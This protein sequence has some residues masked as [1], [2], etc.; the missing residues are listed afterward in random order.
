MGPAAAIA[1]FAAIGVGFAFFFE[2]GVYALF[3]APLIAIPAIR[4]GQSLYQRL[5]WVALGLGLTGGLSYLTFLSAANVKSHGIK[6]SERYAVGN[7][8]A[9]V[10]AQD[11][12]LRLYDTPGSLAQLLAQT[13]LED[14]RTVSNIML[15]MKFV[16]KHFDQGPRKIA[17]APVDGYMIAIYKSGHDGVPAGAGKRWM[18][19]AWPMRINATGLKAYCITPEEDI[20]ETAN[21]EQ[22]YEGLERVPDWTACLQGG[23]FDRP[24]DG[25]AGDGAEWHRWRGKG[26]RRSKAADQKG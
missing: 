7:L 9:L 24:K 16:P 1:A 5:G 18:A 2:W 3:A 19:Y 23:F 11:H 14:G 26:T 8:R 4:S 22:R 20:F 25:I 17:V 13:P 15:P 12:M 6:S 21:T 10:I